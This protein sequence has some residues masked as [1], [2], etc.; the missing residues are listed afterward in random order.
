MQN[1]QTVR[2]KKLRNNGTDTI[3]NMTP[4]AA[5]IN[6]TNNPTRFLLMDG[7]LIEGGI[8]YNERKEKLYPTSQAVAVADGFSFKI[9]LLPGHRVVNGAILDKSG[10]VIYPPTTQM[11]VGP[12]SINLGNPDK[13]EGDSLDAP[14]AATTPDDWKPAA[15]REVPTEA[16]LNKLSVSDLIE[17]AK[18]NKIEVQA[19]AAKGTLVNV[20]VAHFK[21]AGK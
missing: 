1:I 3:Q 8:L 10:N 5:F 20:I 18:A 11:V 16:K 9:E 2:V 7:N 6:V 17:Y 19:T 12:G 21:K 13:P 14:N 4:E 15:A